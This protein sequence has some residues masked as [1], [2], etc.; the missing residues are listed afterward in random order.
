MSMMSLRVVVLTMMV[1]VLM[2]MKRFGVVSQM[3]LHSP[4][5]IL[6]VMVVHRADLAEVD[7]CQ[8]WYVSLS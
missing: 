5:L 8:T 1:V 3:F 4:L 7:P 6:A 2:V